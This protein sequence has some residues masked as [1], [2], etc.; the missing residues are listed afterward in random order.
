[1]KLGGGKS[2]RKGEIKIEPGGVRTHSGVNAAL[3][4]EDARFRHPSGREAISYRFESH[5][6][7]IDS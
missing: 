2:N 1:M 5:V 7:D 6:I 4:E 3:K